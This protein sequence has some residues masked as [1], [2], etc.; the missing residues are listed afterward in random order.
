M[1]IKQVGILIKRSDSV[2]LL[3][4]VIDELQFRTI[5]ELI[6]TELPR[7]IEAAKASGTYIESDEITSGEALRLTDIKTRKEMDG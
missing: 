7:L 6:A 3:H 4:W 5:E 1:I 2:M